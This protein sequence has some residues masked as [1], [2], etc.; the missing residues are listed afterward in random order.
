MF[1]MGQEAKTLRIT[2]V[3]DEKITT[4]IVSCLDGRATFILDHQ[5]PV[6]I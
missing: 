1:N 3:N 2:A 4:E 5:T 6:C